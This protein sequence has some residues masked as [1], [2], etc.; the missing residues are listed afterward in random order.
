MTVEGTAPMG[1]TTNTV[2]TNR[3]VRYVTMLVDKFDPS[4]CE[5][6]TGQSGTGPSGSGYDPCS[7][8]DVRGLRGTAGG[9]GE[10]AA[11]LALQ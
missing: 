8:V 11:K 4:G 10:T 9:A 7:R 6:Y 3:A 1:G 5:N 2:L